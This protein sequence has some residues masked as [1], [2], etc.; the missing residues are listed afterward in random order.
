[1]KEAFWSL[2]LPVG[3]NE[4]VADIWRAYIAQS[5]F[6]FIPHACLMFTSPAVNRSR[7]NYALK[8]DFIK[9]IPLY[10]FSDDFIHSIRNMPLQPGTFS[11]A[12]L[13]VHQQLYETGKSYSK[14]QMLS[15]H[16][17]DLYRYTVFNYRSPNFF[18]K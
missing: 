8:N 7:N 12:F 11:S 14:A 3:V 1:L 6:H 10:M 15:G 17:N 4:R 9:E 13:A 2:M 18:L 16:T 5:L